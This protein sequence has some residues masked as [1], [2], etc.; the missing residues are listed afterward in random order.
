L[1]QPAT[2]LQLVY[3]VEREGLGRRRLA[4]RTGWSE[5]TVRL[6]LERLR[7][8]GLLE[9]PRAGPRLTPL[10][11]RRFGLSLRRILD[12]R[13]LE[14]TSLRVDAACLGGRMR[15]G[16]TPNAWIARD[17][18]VRAG[19]SGLILLGFGEDGWTFSHDGEPVDRKNP[20][21]AERL[22]ASFE[23]AKPGDVLLL[24]F[25]PTAEAAGHGLWALLA[26]LLAT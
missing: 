10:G 12:V 18:A 14:L 23:G 6:E 16:E 9:L 7:N 3:Y 11:R 26:D 24:S 25:G 20:G 15:E 2:T 5:M 17:A 1:T 8:E 22:R 21:D 4:E 13:P 19:A